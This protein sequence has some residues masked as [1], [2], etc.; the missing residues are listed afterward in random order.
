MPS[1]WLETSSAWRRPP[2]NRV[3]RAT[4][5]GNNGY[6]APCDAAR[7][8]PAQI[9]PP[10]LVPRVAH[11]RAAVRSVERTV[12]SEDLL[13]VDGVDERWRV[14]VTDR[15]ARFRAARGLLGQIGPGPARRQKRLPPLPRSLPVERES[16]HER[17]ASATGSLDC[18]IEPG[19]GCCYG[20]GSRSPPAGIGRCCSWIAERKRRA[21]RGDRA[22]FMLPGRPLRG[23]D[24]GA[25]RMRRAGR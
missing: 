1:V 4:V 20:T 7:R 11:R 14:G 12:S 19:R 2:P 8:V 17:V 22:G 25:G 24:R 10:L 23:A 16:G 5:C 9:G 21:R 3:K 18:S 6:T 15:R 13:M